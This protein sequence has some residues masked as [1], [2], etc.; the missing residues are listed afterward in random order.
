M[1]TLLR[2]NTNQ[3]QIEKNDM[4]IKV[5]FWPPYASLMSILLGTFWSINSGKKTNCLLDPSRPGFWD[6]GHIWG[7]LFETKFAFWSHMASPDVP[8]LGHWTVSNTNHGQ[9]KYKSTYQSQTFKILM[10]NFGSVLEN[11]KIQ[12]YWHGSAFFW[13]TG[14]NGQRVISIV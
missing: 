14:C 3:G 8:L 1:G 10:L 6:F 9:T 12:E 13:I 4:V 11:H 7:K 5:N 2:N